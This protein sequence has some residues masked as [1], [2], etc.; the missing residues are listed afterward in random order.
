M[1]QAHEDSRGRSSREAREPRQ[2]HQPATASARH[3]RASGHGVR[4][5]LGAAVVGSN[6]RRE[7][8]AGL[9]LDVR[10]HDGRFSRWTS[11][12]VGRRQAACAAD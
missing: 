6:L 12:P 10:R 8:P 9:L 2:R 11:G 5:A 3:V 7:L 1:I 4:C